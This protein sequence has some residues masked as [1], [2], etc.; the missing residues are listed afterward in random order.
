MKKCWLLL[1]LCSCTYTISLNHTEGVADD[2]G[3]EYPTATADVNANATLNGLK[4]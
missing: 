1:V 4:K 3:D 2:V